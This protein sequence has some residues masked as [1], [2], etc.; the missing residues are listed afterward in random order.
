[1]YLICFVKSYVYFAQ[2]LR[3]F[4]KNKLKLF[5]KLQTDLRTIKN[6]ARLNSLASV[7]GCNKREIENILKTQIQKNRRSQIST[8]SDV[9]NDDITKNL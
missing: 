6:G 7:D 4:C 2:R 1:M 8:F 9:P 3:C 5:V